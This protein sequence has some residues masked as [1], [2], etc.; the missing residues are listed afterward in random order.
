VASP[1]IREPQREFEKR[2]RTYLAP[3]SA[4]A[5][6]LDT[7][8]ILLP[9]PISREELAKLNHLNPGRVV[10]EKRESPYGYWLR[11]RLHQPSREAIQYLQRNFPGHIVNRVDIAYDFSVPTRTVARHLRLLARQHITQRWH[12]N[13]RARQ[14]EET[15]YSRGITKRWA[16]RVIVKYAD[17]PSKLDSA[18]ALH[19]E[20]RFQGAEF[21]KRIG[22]R[23]VRDVLDLD[24]TSIFLRNCRLS[25][26]LSG[27]L[28]KQLDR[29]V[30]EHVLAQNRRCQP[31]YGKLP[32]SASRRIYSLP[33]N[34]VVAASC[35]RGVCAALLG[36]VDHHVSLYGLADASAQCFIDIMPRFIDFMPN[37]R[38]AVVHSTSR[39]LCE[40]PLPL[41]KSRDPRFLVYPF[42]P[43]SFSRPRVPLRPPGMEPLLAHLLRRGWF[44]A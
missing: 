14:I 10:R 18:P 42:G 31:R 23:Q 43:Q 4:R 25:L 24:A 11:L 1:I 20:L 12:G 44:N 28:D 2:L 30:G 15:T 39:L 36:E 37:I 5:A 33:T 34:R 13:H 40:F 19:I 3:V 38:H 21:C 6:Y 32:R 29:I 22:V 17:K 7:L 16:G 27:K 8:Q 9:S 26:V 41:I 35:I